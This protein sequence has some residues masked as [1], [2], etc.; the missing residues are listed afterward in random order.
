M[1]LSLVLSTS[2]F[3]QNTF[4]A[5]SGTF[6]TMHLFVVKVLHKH[7]IEMSSSN[8]LLY[9]SGFIIKC[10]GSFYTIVHKKPD[11]RRSIYFP[12]FTLNFL[13]L[14][15]VNH[16]LISIRSSTDHMEISLS[17]QSILCL[18]T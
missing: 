4:I 12:G 11:I 9:S 14:P 7:V 5:F 13:T 8:S 3:P 10:K 18:F 15:Y 17:D 1:S 2:F 16:M 6:A